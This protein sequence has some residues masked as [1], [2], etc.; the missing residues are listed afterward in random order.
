MTSH[1]EGAENE[2]RGRRG[3]D[4][5]PGRWPSA[6][7]VSGFT[8]LELLVAMS[9][10]VML[11]TALLLI[12]RGGLAT[13]RRGEARQTTY[14]A[15]QALL[16]Q[17]REDLEHAVA[18]HDTTLVQGAGEVDARLLADQD[19]AGRP[20]LFLVRAIKAESE[21]PITGLAGNTIGGDAVVDYRDDLEEGRAARLRATGGL[22][23][24]AWVLG[25]GGLL[26]RGVKA[27]VG[28]P[29]SLFDAQGA[30]ELSPPR[31]VLGGPGES[32]TEPSTAPAP[33]PPPASGAL[34]R[35]FAEG[36]LFLEWRFWTQ[37]STTWQLSKKP[38]RFPRADAKEESGPLTYWDSTRALLAPVDPND[39]RRWDTFKSQASLRD[40]RDDVFPAKVRLEVT[41]EEPPAAGSTTVLEQAIDAKE[42]R[43]VLREVGRLPPKGGF[44]RIGSEWVEVTGEPEGA[45]IRVER[46][47][48]GTAAVAHAAEDEVVVGRTFVIVVALPAC[49]ED[50]SEREPRR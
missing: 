11:G 17:L 40:P 50:W 45:S 27:P 41:L 1:A 4:A 49:R 30:Y 36:V 38:I 3:R 46:G 16:G 24:V 31:P 5:D 32:V 18:P 48:R 29:G 23:E 34:L 28:P 26:Y 42:D 21:H 10:L 19:D 7:D 6:R 8:L 43:L 35:P 25:P 20:R 12:L 33:P 44:A 22:M 2:E 13:W 39:P 15:G 9:V 14:A 47:R 37:H